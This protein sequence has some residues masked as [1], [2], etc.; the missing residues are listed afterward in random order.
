MWNYSPY[1]TSVGHLAHIILP[2]DPRPAFD[3]LVDRD[4]QFNPNAWIP[5]VE[6]AD[7]SPYPL[8]WRLIHEN[9]YEIP[10]FAYARLREETLVIFETRLVIHTPSFWRVVQLSV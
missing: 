4:R 6:L 8:E 1:L 3:Q 2:D 7:D 5:P 9:G 10:A